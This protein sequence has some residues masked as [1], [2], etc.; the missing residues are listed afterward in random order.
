MGG[1]EVH[2][3]KRDMGCLELSAADISLFGMNGTGAAPVSNGDASQWLLK[4]MSCTEEA[5][6][7]FDLLLRERSV[8]DL[9]FDL[10]ASNDW[11]STDSK[12]LGD[13]SARTVE[14]AIAKECDVHFRT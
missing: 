5:S 9:T 12:K 3:P 14:L 13:R 11:R 1:D 2:R 6:C 10:P 7:D 4:A 8:R